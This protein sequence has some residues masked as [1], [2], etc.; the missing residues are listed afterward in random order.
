MKMTTLEKIAE[1]LGGKVRGDKVTKTE[2]KD[3]MRGYSNGAD[4]TS[5]EVADL[6]RKP[7]KQES[8]KPAESVDIFVDDEDDI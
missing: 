5:Y 3:L 4:D 2:L 6:I 7:I 1:E 8:E